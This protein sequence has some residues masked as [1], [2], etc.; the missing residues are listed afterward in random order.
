MGS[1][2]GKW[3][4]GVGK[5]TVGVGKWTVG[6][7]SRGKKLSTS[8]PILCHVQLHFDDTVIKRN[9]EV[10]FGRTEGHVKHVRCNMQF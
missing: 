1:G 3:T 7:C 4:V 6:V 2:V 5:W 9:V 10:S 8:G